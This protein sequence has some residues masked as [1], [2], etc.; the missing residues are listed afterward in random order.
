M[1]RQ[2]VLPHPDG[3]TMATNS[4]SAIARSIRSSATDFWPNVL[5]T[6]SKLIAA[7]ADA[8]RHQAAPAHGGLEPAQRDVDRKPDHADRHHG[9]HHG[10]GRDIE[11][12]LHHHEADAG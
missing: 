4:R 9:A 3:P 7:I 11:L 2:V 5:V 8:S 12:G 10:R 1:R 6:A